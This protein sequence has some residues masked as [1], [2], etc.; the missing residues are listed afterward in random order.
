[1]PTS[2]RTNVTDTGYTYN[3]MNYKKETRYDG[4]NQP[5]VVDVPVG[6]ASAPIPTASPT[7]LVTS[8]ASRNEFATNQNTMQKA[9][10]SLASRTPAGSTENS[11]TPVLNY[12]A[13][14]G[15]AGSMENIKLLASKYGMTY[16]GSD[17]DNAKLAGFI[18]TV[19]SNEPSQPKNPT[20]GTRE[21]VYSKPDAE[22]KIVGEN[23]GLLG[24][25][26]SDGTYVDA[27]GNPATYD[28]AT[29]SMT[30]TGASAGGTSTSD[31]LAGFRA[32]SS[33]DPVL[34]KQYTD[35][36]GNLDAGIANAKKA[37]EE[38]TAALTDDPS[39]NA[40]IQQIMQK[41]DKQIEL[42]KNKNTILMG[43]HKRNAARS[44]MAQYANDMSEDFLS[45]EQDKATQRITDLITEETT[46]VL[47]AKEAFKSGR[48]E[49]FAKATKAYEDANKDKIKAIN[50]L[51]K[52]TND[53]VKLLQAEEKADAQNEKSRMA[54]SIKNLEVSSPALAKEFASLTDPKDQKDFI[55]H[56]AESFG[57]DGAV[58]YGAI[59]KAGIA[60]ESA[61]ALTEQRKRVKN[62]T[63]TK[64]TVS[65]TNKERDDDIAEAVQRFQ[66][67]TQQ[68]G[69]YGVDPAEYDFYKDYIKTTYGAAAV[70]KFDKAVK[71]AKLRI[72]KVGDGVGGNK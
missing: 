61:E 53:Q 40:A 6:S 45:M 57:L 33:L 69:L 21:A 71:D 35:A 37:L 5:Y 63:G 50:D 38:A 11:Y 19:P 41:Y 2:E 64:K 54:T 20:A 62:G 66:L 55:D 72:D 22:G 9:E 34:M 51:L 58:V 13:S 1:M 4:N 18:K 39:A 14:Q 70:T 26:N 7:L 60:N 68:E 8:N 10:A 16:T 43:S 23:N 56:F 36:I 30:A 47:K 49:E 17:E 46:M 27:N 67:R 15:Q 25:K 31:P 12:L 42:M 28:E 3:G 52:A 59:T 65:Q 24:Y 44:G 32:N 48:L 29:G